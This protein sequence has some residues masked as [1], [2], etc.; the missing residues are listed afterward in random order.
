MARFE[1]RVERDLAIM[2]SLA[3]RLALEAG[4]TSR[5][6][7]RLIEGRYDVEVVNENARARRIP[8]A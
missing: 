5:W 8:R 3:V 2:M 6:M 4:A 7:Q 1:V